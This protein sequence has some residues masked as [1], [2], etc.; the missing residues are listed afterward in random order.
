[1]KKN[2]KVLKSRQRKKNKIGTGSPSDDVVR[3][4]YGSA[5][6]NSR[7]HGRGSQLG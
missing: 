4:D 6:K 5:G 7:S 3:G 2:V 1:M